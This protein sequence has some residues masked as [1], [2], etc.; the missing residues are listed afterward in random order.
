[1]PGKYMKVGRIGL[2]NDVSEDK[3]YN[4]FV[5]VSLKVEDIEALI[6]SASEQGVD[7]IKITSQVG[8]NNYK[9]DNDKA[10]PYS[11]NVSF[12]LD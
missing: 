6:A 2:W 3:D 8:V 7:Y 5:S 1:M 9:G 12:R 10:P 4:Y 11:G